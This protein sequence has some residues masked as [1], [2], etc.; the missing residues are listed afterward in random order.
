MKKILIIPARRHILE[1]YCE[2]IIRYL[3]SEFYFEMGYPP[4]PPYHTIQERVWTGATSP[5]EKNPDEFDLIYPQF[6]TH[7]FLEPPEK[8][9][10][11]IAIV[12]LEP[13]QTPKFSDKIAVWGITS[14]PLEVS[15]P[16]ACKLR[17]G[18][19]TNLFQPFPQARLDDKLHVGFLGNIQT[20]R[21]YLKDLFLPLSE[22]DGVTLDIYP[23]TWSKK[24]RPDEI[25]GMGGQRILEYIRGGD[26]WLSGV[27]N[28]YNRMDIYVRCD[29]DHGYQLS[30]MEAAACGIPVVATDSGIT[31]ELCDAGGGILIDCGDRSDREEN[32]HRVR[33]RI[34]EAVIFL[35]HHPQLRKEMGMKG[36]AF[37]QE[38]YQWEKWIPAW[39]EFF[40][41]GL[42][43]SNHV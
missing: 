15:Y 29:I 9:A 4:E 33:S 11:K 27:P 41:K 34:L 22:L 38:Q 14:Q 30:V 3:G 35:N 32:L 21:R 20:P 26:T 39:R 36:R 7:W 43:A 1:A 24:T 40:Q 23:T 37:V 12:M 28:I 6:S 5:L 8:Y 2:Y 42:D 16:T 31:K 13:R 25:E 19:D 17:F 18:V 10:H